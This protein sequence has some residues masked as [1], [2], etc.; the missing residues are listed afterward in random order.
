M[1]KIE[2]IVV[3]ERTLPLVQ[4]LRYRVYCAEK[5]FAMPG[6]DHEAR[7][8]F[9]EADSLGVTFAL[10]DGADLVSSA[11][12]IPVDPLKAPD[13]FAVFDLRNALPRPDHGAVI[14][15]KLVTAPDRRGS[16]TLGPVMRAVLDFV[17]QEKRRYIAI[18]AEPS[19]RDFYVSMGFDIMKED[20]D[21]AP[22]GKVALMVFDMRDER[23][24]SGKSLAGWMFKSVFTG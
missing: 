13:K 20:I 21:A 16:K 6:A 14:V 19:M 10:F 9:D 12:V 15:S 8:L 11:Q 18:L 3:D 24:T 17:A 7:M 22:F 23:H 4:H 5:Q 2:L 1:S